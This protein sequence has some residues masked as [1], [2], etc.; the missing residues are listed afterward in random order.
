M[1]KICL[2]G[3][4]GFISKNFL[5]Q[6]Y[7]NNYNVIAINKK[8]LLKKTKHIN[9]TNFLLHFAGT[10][11]SS[12]KKDFLDSNIEL[13][14]TLLKNIN[15]SKKP[16]IIYLSTI[17]IN[18]KNIYGITK[19]K[20]EKLLIDFC[21]KEKLSI[22]IYRLPNTFGKWSKP[23]YN[24]VVSTF[25]YSIINNINYENKDPN[26]V[27]T[28][29]YVGDIINSINKVVNKKKHQ[30]KVSFKNDYKK[31]HVK[32]KKLE[33]IILSFKD[34][35][36][37]KSIDIFNS[38]FNRKLYSVYVSYFK[39]NNFFYKVE[40]NEDDRGR[41]SEFLKSKNL[42]QVSA[43]TIKSKKIRG[44]HYHHYKTEKF[45]IIKGN[46]EVTYID[47]SDRK[48]KFKKIFNDASSNVVETIPGYY[49]EIKNIGKQDICVLLW[50]NEVFNPL[51]PDTYSLN[52]KI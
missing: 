9:D 45:L 14:K 22:Y 36:N 31:Y 49:H 20:G 18:E 39:K 15:V 5:T 48:N 41:F 16:I 1:N 26:K 30:Y 44:C 42:G 27:I 8:N 7:L 11:R 2:I 25:C 24:S 29:S 3:S 32:L 33:E 13:T 43:F 38:S 34:I 6:D 21:K 4:D 46:Y 35:R 10:N 28:M 50:S 23:F 52:E 17:K 12:I 37:N 19:K 47:I 40:S 51:K